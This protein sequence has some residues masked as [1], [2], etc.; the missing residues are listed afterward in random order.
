[1]KTYRKRL[2]NRSEFVCGGLRVL[3]CQLAHER[4]FSNRRKSDEPNTSNTSSGDIEADT[5]T[6][7][8]A[9][10]LEQFSF[11]F[12]EFCLQLSCSIISMVACGLRSLNRTKMERRRLVLLGLGH[13]KSSGKSGSTCTCSRESYFGLNIFDLLR[14]TR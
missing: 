2:T 8:A 5:S 14:E 4:T 6:A 11:E 1:M 3:S 13:L 10:G 9:A 12:C 7:S